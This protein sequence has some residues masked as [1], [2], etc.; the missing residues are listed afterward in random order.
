MKGDMKIEVEDRHPLAIVYLSGEIA[1]MGVY[2]VKSMLD[3]WAREGKRY[4]VIS[5]ADV[6]FLDS[7]GIG[8]LL[9]IR[10]SC[11]TSG[12]G[13]AMIQSASGQVMRTL[14]IASLEKLIPFFTNMEDAL[15]YLHTKF[16]IVAMPPTALS[17]LEDLAGVVNDLTQRLTLIEERLTRI[18][19]RLEK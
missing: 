4:L 8:L 12:G 15:K 17:T 14:E 5:L 10:N 9:Q 3:T 18:E 11:H 19:S 7:A 16:G 1:A 2:K 6:S 13:V